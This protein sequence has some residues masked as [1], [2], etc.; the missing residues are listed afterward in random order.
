MA[1]IINHTTTPRTTATTKP[2][3]E[4]KKRAVIAIRK[5]GTEANPIAIRITNPPAPQTV[6]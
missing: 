2:V 3:L 4:P 6:L 1:I 5:K